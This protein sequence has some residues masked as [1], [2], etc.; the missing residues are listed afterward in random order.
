MSVQ[1]ALTKPVDEKTIAAMFDR[2]AG[3]YDFLNRLLSAR[4]D[5]RWRRKLIEMVPYRPAGRYL[6]MATGAK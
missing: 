3:R 6:D 2:I 1:T 4:Q 5:V